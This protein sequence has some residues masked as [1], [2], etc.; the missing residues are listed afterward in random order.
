MNSKVPSPEIL[1]TSLRSLS[2]TPT[3]GFCVRGGYMKTK[4]CNDCGE[5]KATT[6]FY[7]GSHGRAFKSSCKACWKISNAAY[8]KK[9]AQ[10]MNDYVNA[11]RKKHPE[12]LREMCRKSGKKNAKRKA[13]YNREY[14]RLHPEIY[15]ARLDVHRALTSGKLVRPC[16]CEECGNE[17]VPHGHHENYF[18]PL[19]VAWL[20]SKC[21]AKKHPRRMLCPSDE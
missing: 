2:V 9:N 10:K 4:R 13:E 5:K 8:R 19:S 21:H 15:A 14:F 17:C 18:L 3:G 20:C 7:K 11:W 12:R 16:S 6:E 1:G